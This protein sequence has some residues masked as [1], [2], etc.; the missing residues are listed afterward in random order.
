MSHNCVHEFLVL[1]LDLVDSCLNGS[2]LALVINKS[3]T[4]VAGIG[5]SE[6]TDIVKLGTCRGKDN[7]LAFFVLNALFLPYGV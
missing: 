5:K 4:N 3:C 2:G 1:S 7:F 6:N